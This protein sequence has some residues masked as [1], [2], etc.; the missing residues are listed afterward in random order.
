MKFL[1]IAIF[2][3]GMAHAKINITPG[4]WDVSMKINHGGKVIDPNEQMKAALAKMPAEKRK[5]MEQMMQ[6]MGAGDL[7]GKG[8]KVCYSNE[9]LQQDTLMPQTENH[10]CKTDVKTKNDSKVVTDFTCDDG[11]KGTATWEIKSE[12]EF[13][14]EVKVNKA[15]KDSQINYNGKFMNADCGK[16]K[17]YMKKASK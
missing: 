13:L 10:K 3:S 12:K 11:A 8:V 2:S 6:Q 5:K 17:P 9:M 7:T 4:L 1:L 14:G 16:I 15:G